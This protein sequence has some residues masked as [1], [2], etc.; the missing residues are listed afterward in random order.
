MTTIKKW[1]AMTNG[2]R[3]HDL[4]KLLETRRRK[5]GS[6]VQSK[7]RNGRDH[8]NEREVLDEGESSEVDVQDEIGFALV[9]MKAETLKK[10]DASLRRLREGTYGACCECGGEIPEARLRALPFA[11]RCKECEEARE[12]AEQRERV[13]SKGQWQLC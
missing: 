13:V 6:D 3:D 12:H 8:T 2:G 1:T 7:I 4:R 10:V 11:V 5:L 9:Q